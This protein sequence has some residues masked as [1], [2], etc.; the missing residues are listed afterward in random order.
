MDSNG[1]TFGRESR[2]IGGNNNMDDGPDLII[3][4][5]LAFIALA[6]LLH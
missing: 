5:V 2:N 1:Q 4:I 3:W 6:I